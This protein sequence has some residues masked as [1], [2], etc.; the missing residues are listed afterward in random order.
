MHSVLK[1]RRRGLANFFRRLTASESELYAEQVRGERIRA[2]CISADQHRRGEYATVSGRLT[3]VLI[4]PIATMPALEAELF[5]GSSTV[6][7]VWLG[8][9]HITGVEPGRRLTASGRIAIR[10]PDDRVIFNPWY[11]LA[12]STKSDA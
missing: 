11:D 2:G 1:D 10:V 8:R 12:L 6:T 4:T 9:H 5:D 3:T 7:L